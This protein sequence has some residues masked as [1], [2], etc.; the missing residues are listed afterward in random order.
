MRLIVIFF[1]FLA[2]I[3]VYANP[4]KFTFGIVPSDE[5]APGSAGQDFDMGNAKSA[6]T[7]GLCFDIYVPAYMLGQ[8]FQTNFHLPVP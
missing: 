3:C 7:P 8:R 5:A 4:E 2:M 6:C 1:V